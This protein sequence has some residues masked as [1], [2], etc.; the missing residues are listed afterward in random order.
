MASAAKR[1]R[2]VAVS[3]EEVLELL[4]EDSSNEGMSNDEESDLDRQM[5]SSSDELR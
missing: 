1:L 3:A 2:T 4:E 5:Q